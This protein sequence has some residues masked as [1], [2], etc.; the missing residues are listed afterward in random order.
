MAPFNSAK[1]VERETR[2]NGSTNATNGNMSWTDD[3]L[4]QLF[5]DAASNATVEYNDAYWKDIEGMLPV[6]KKRK[7]LLW[8]MGGAGAL[9]FFGTLLLV[10]VPFTTKST[11]AK[12]PVR[13]LASGS[14]TDMSVNSS[15]SS[16]VKKSVNST[17]SYT[18]LIDTKLNS[19]DKQS[20][21]KFRKVR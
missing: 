1:S 4:D 13:K 12:E 8:W 20:A 2:K 14:T 3:E 9:V 15:A 5:S 11:V 18:S 17:E 21:I 6:R 16:Q 19:A 7:G 10:Q